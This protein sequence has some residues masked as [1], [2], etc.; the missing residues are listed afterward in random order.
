MTMKKLLTILCLV[1][2]VSCSDQPPPEVPYEVPSHRLVK[3]GGMT[4]EIGS[5][6]PFTGTSIE[7]HENGQPEEKIFY[8]NGR[9]VSTTEFDYYEN[10][11]LRSRSNYKNGELDGLYEGFYENGQLRSR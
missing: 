2:L 10:G 1:L 6:D 3:N 7:Y 4:F 8:K 9:E 5:N 11:Q